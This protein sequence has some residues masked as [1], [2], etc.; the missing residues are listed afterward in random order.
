MTQGPRDVP[1]HSGYGIRYVK[2]QET[3][4]GYATI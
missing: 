1:V 4:N 3:R 2:A